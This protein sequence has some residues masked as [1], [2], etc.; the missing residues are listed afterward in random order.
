MGLF[1]KKK[2]D[3]AEVVKL[4]GLN[5]CDNNNV[6]LSVVKGVL[7]HDSDALSFAVSVE[8]NT[9][10]QIMRN[11]VA[12]MG[13]M[14]QIYFF[15]KDFMENIEAKVENSLSHDEKLSVGLKTNA[16][17][18]NILV[19]LGNKK[20]Y[21]NLFIN[22]VKIGGNA[23]L[24][25]AT[26]ATLNVPRSS[27]SATNAPV[28]PFGGFNLC[29]NVNVGLLVDKGGLISDDTMLSFAVKVD[30]NT[31]YYVTRNEVGL[32]NDRFR[33]FFYSDD[34]VK[35]KKL[36][37]DRTLMQDG[38]K[39]IAFKTLMNTHYILIYLGKRNL[40]SNVM[41]NAIKIAPSLMREISKEGAAYN[42]DALFQKV[43]SSWRTSGA[44][45][46]LMWFL[47]FTGRSFWSWKNEDNRIWLVYCACLIERG[48]REDA[49]NLLKK[50]IGFYGLKDVECFLSVSQLADTIGLS[51]ASVKKASSVLTQ[52]EY[53]RE[54]AIFKKFITGKTIAVVGNGGSD[55]GKGLGEEINAHDIVI[56]FNNY[57]T[58][59]ESDYGTKTDI[60]VRG[61]AADV[62]D[63][64]DI[65]NIS[66]VIWEPD[67]THN[68]LLLSHLN[69]LFRDI[70]TYPEK[71]LYID[72]EIKSS[73]RDK[74][75]FAQIPT[76]G[77]GML[78]MLYNAR[79]SL[80]DIDVY[81]FSFLN[82]NYED[83]GH[84]YDNLSKATE[85]HETRQEY[86]FLYEL[87]YGK[88]PEFSGGSRDG[89]NITIVGC[90]YREYSVEKGKTGG[91]GGVLAMQEHLFGDEYRGCKQIY[92]F[93]T[94][95]QKHK[96]NTAIFTRGLWGKISCNFVA[97]D[98][99]QNSEIIAKEAA[100]GSE[101]LFVCHDI[102]SAY[103]AYL[104]GYKYVIVYHQ[105]G[106]LINEVEAAGLVPSERDRILAAKLE[107]E[108]FEN[109]QKVFFPSLGARNTFINTSQVG[110]SEEIPYA[111]HALYN[112]IFDKTDNIVSLDKYKLPPKMGKLSVFISIGDFN[113]D[114]GM[115]RVPEFLER[116]VKMSGN[117]ALWIA[118]GSAT[119][120][121]IY[122][123]I[124]A[125][126]DYYDFKSIVIGE[127][128]GH[129]E[130]LALIDYADYFVMLQRNSIFDLATLEAL[131]A[132]KCVILSDVGGNPEFNVDDNVVLVDSDDYDTAIKDILKRNTVK[133]GQSNRHTFEQ[134]F[135][136]QRFVERYSAMLDEQLVNM[137]V[138]AIRL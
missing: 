88:Q 64:L 13:D 29:N 50:Y 98:F 122:N 68:R 110:K 100:A 41:V 74:M 91:P 119:N 55:L 118:A 125:S 56:R 99:V 69:I 14:F 85:W 16:N 65:E 126:Q 47:D 48:K 114:K 5:L 30:P 4:G 57:P 82:L 49:E 52:L 51:N 95:E 89:K 101:L 40:Y 24:R 80:D 75:G 129:D 93:L 28:S 121:D 116:Y 134:N 84:Y 10:Y 76:S 105:Q 127:R 26:H 36:K 135:S 115:D 20:K 138:E 81:G 131:R 38:Q 35:N 19:Y 17:T 109:A 67:F 25:P 102:G 106:S 136:Q 23:K 7:V 87:R 11:E 96:A 18:S 44:T 77:C 45:D 60:W 37:G 31:V 124:V 97:A 70:V 132:G 54:S 6:E 2:I 92:L 108:V 34:F 3:V 59:Y 133:W 117:K 123:A 83:T 111:N 39:E 61:G 120:K 130:L 79:G 63:K 53:N 46:S 32:V 112:T 33:I 107:R 72:S 78:W 71:I 12:S 42:P 113:N 104:C 103:G 66:F 58:G 9:T 15:D 94:D 43:H 137:G 86:D 27:V 62:T 73:L 22:M 8:S 128:V 1:G 21:S 90:A